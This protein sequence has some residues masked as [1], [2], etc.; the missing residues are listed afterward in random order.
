MSRK[1]KT[2]KRKILQDP[3]YNSKLA[4]MIINKILMKGKKSLAQHI[5]Y[6][7]MKLIKEKTKKDEL[8]ILQKAI[9]NITPMV[10]LKSRRVGG[11][12]FSVPVEIKQER[13][14][15]IALSFLI[16]SAR[17]RPGTKII[18]KL[19]NELIDAANNTGASVK[20]KDELHR[21]SEANKAFANFKF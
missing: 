4:S 3:I 19:S 16:K 15:S 10:E 14:I 6:E 17:N 21:M 8:E 20:K 18:N 7:S 12:T 13:G 9:K 11:S 5:F 1:N 2:K